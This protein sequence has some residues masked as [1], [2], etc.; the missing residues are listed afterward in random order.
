MNDI[1]EKFFNV[2]YALYTGSGTTALYM[3]LSYLKQ[4]GLKSI[5]IPTIICPQVPIVAEKLNMSVIFSDV[6][7]ENYNLDL[8]CVKKIYNEHKFD[9][10]LFSHI[11]GYECDRE[12]IDF[13]KQHGIII[14]EDAA[15]TY[16]VNNQCDFNIMSFGHTKF[17]ENKNLGGGLFS[18]NDEISLDFK[19]SYLPNNVLHKDNKD[20]FLAYKSNFETYRE[21]FYKLDKNSFQ[22]Y[23][24]LYELLMLHTIFLDDSSYNEL[25]IEKMNS[26][27][28]ICNTRLY[29]YHLYLKNLNHP[30]I[31]HPNLPQNTIPWRYTFRFLGD[32]ELFLFKLREKD[33]DC[34]SWYDGCD[35]IFNAKQ[36]FSNTRILEKQLV[37]LWIDNN[38]LFN[39]KHILDVLN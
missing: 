27:K 4:N 18:N 17:L 2:K 25:L 29:N 36:N 20:E 15:Q 7:L 9:I 23:N 13:C 10:L 19:K 39:I 35:K 6:S 38:V 28:D 31:L 26:M 3:C 1:L 33:I 24:K 16:K 32:R 22:Y 21:K 37:N 12:I 5:L 8:D 30:L 34:S 14:I 11:Y